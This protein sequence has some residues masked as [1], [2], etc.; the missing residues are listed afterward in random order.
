MKVIKE[1][2]NQIPKSHVKTANQ[3]F[4]NSSTSS[5]IYVTKLINQNKN[6]IK[7][8]NFI[9]ESLP[10]LKTSIQNIFSNDDKREKIFRYLIQKNK[11]HTANTSKDIKRS[12]QTPEYKPIKK[13]ELQEKRIISPYDNK[14]YY[15]FKPI[16]TTYDSNQSCVDLR[17]TDIREKNANNMNYK[18]YRYSVATPEYIYNDEPFWQSNRI[19]RGNV[20]S[21]W[22]NNNNTFT[23]LL[24][25]NNSINV[26]RNRGNKY[27][28]IS[29]YNTY[30]NTFNNY[31]M[32]KN[33]VNKN[34]ANQTYDFG[35]E[36]GFRSTLVKKNKNPLEENPFKDYIKNSN[37]S[38]FRR[39]FLEKNNKNIIDISDHEN[40]D[41]KNN[42]EINQDNN[43]E[44]ILNKKNNYAKRV[45][46]ERIKVQKNENLN[47]KKHR[48]KNNDYL[49]KN[50]SN[51]D[52][53]IHKILGYKKLNQKKNI[54]NDLTSIKNESKIKIEINDINENENNANTNNKTYEKRKNYYDLYGHKDIHV[55]TL[56]QKTYENENMK[57]DNNKIDLNVNTIKVNIDKNILKNYNNSPLS[58][59]YNKYFIGNK[60]KLPN[61]RF[62]K[63]TYEKRDTI[64][65][66]PNPNF[67]NAE[68]N[69]NNNK[70]VFKDEE[71]I[72][73]YIKKKYNKRNIDEI[74]N[75]ENNNK[76][77]Y[78][79]KKEKKEDHMRMMT[80]EEGKKI[81]QKNDELSN[82]INN[83]K[84][85]NRRCKKELNDMKNRFNDLT[86]EINTIK[87]NK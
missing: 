70:L 62:I 3:D 23:N 33:K 28:H 32:Q 49:I 42:N 31:R 16:I 30:N 4:S 10:N 22:Q 12:L 38:N 76:A 63:K 60:N 78:E 87:E 85:E 6:K 39:K 8:E 37:L 7:N 29:I 47:M 65:R 72:I 46:N 40:K 45:K 1:K 57:D 34:F 24:T 82:E 74:I 67:N 83:L 41:N 15:T 79:P 77:I 17:R 21:F 44:N 59:R 71:E 53:Y 69:N 80:T 36:Y 26:N 48:N 73:E 61:N 52:F 66:S 5:N 2:E 50:E 56:T 55:N 9:N 11:Q 75:R 51:R 13:I 27:E 58:Y 20:N 19:Y 64:Q 84:C 18:G 35:K 86:K 68:N 54:N 14:N 25:N 43:N 81:E